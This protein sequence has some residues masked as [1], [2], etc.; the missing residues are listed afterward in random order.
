MYQAKVSSS[1]TSL[2]EEMLTNFQL[3][4]RIIHYCLTPLLFMPTYV[5]YLLLHIIFRG[6]NYVEHT[7]TFEI[8][9]DTL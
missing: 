9:R 4:G 6:N 7:L 8:S 2:N 1:N 5:H 3:H